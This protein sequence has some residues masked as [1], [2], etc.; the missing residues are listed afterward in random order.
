M[1]R[2]ALLSAMQGEIDVMRAI[3]GQNPYI[4]NLEAVYEDK[5]M[6][7]IV[8]EECRGGELFDRIR[9]RGQYNEHDAAK[10]LK[11]VG[12]ALRFMHVMHQVVHCDLKPDN[13]LFL[14]KKDDSPIKIIDFGMAKVLPRLRTL[15]VKLCGAPYY[16]APEILREGE[17]YSHG[18]DMW[19]VGVIM[20]VML[21]GFPPFYVDP[22]KYY[23]KHEAQA[24][25]ALVCYFLLF[26][27]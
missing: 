22:N 15:T 21:F 20:F 5:H 26:L 19:S 2:Q 3:K 27:L 17:H 14:T 12:D 23:G 13:I 18:G 7:Y 8:M 16:T 6:L 9:K 25:Y 10:V 24:I 1:Q 4:V 11:M